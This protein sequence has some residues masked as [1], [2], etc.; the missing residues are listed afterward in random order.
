LG[1]VRGWDLHFVDLI[2]VSLRSIESIIVK[3]V[4]NVA[5]P[6]DR[7]NDYANNDGVTS[8]WNAMLLN[9]VI[10]GKGK[11]LIQDNTTLTRPPLGFDSVSTLD[12]F[13]SRGN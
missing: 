9:K 6:P 13:S 8:D 2:K 10:V 7:S 4:S 12:W 1:E 11:K 5:I 3:C